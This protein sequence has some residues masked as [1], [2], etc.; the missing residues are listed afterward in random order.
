MIL[1]NTAFVKK[2][3]T[4]AELAAKVEEVLYPSG[5]VQL[6]NNVIPKSLGH[7]QANLSLGISSVTGD[8]AL[9]QSIHSALDGD[10]P[11]VLPSG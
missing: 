10:E 9:F 7:A 5:D 8:L 1:P 2:P 4:I 3:F 11:L 6:G